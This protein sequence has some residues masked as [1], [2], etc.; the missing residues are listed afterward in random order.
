MDLKS[1]HST[2]DAPLGVPGVPGVS[3]VS[4]IKKNILQIKMLSSWAKIDPK[5]QKLQKTFKIEKSC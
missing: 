1:I 4:E 2:I 5:L 3:G